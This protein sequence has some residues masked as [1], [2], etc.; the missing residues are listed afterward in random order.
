[1]PEGGLLTTLQPHSSLHPFRVT[2]RPHLLSLGASQ[3]EEDAANHLLRIPVSNL[4]FSCSQGG[5]FWKDVNCHQSQLIRSRHLKGRSRLSQSGAW[6]GAHLED[7][8][9]LVEKP[10]EKRI[11]S[12]RDTSLDVTRPDTSF[13]DEEIGAER[14]NGLSGKAGQSGDCN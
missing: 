1:M 3:S 5:G 11:T 2:G 9:H 7:T 13:C 8:L 10:G 14:R 4:I 6:T 12:G